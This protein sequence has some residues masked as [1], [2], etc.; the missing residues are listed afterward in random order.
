MRKS[1]YK[2]HIV[3][4]LSLSGVLLLGCILLTAWI[5]PFFHYHKPLQGFRYTID[6]Q[7]S[8]NPGIASTFDYDSVILGS[9]MTINFDTDLFRETMG[10]ETVKLSYNGAFPK[11][12]DNIMPLV[13]N[14]HNQVKEIFLG[15]DISTYKELPGITAYGIPE[16]L[17]DDSLWNDLPYLLNKDVLLEYIMKNIFSKQPGT[18]LNEIYCS[19]HYVE[20]SK[21]NVLA[22]YQAPDR[23]LEPLSAD[24][25]MENIEK[26]MKDYILPYIEAMPETQF[27]VFFPPYSILYWYTQFADG[28]LEAQLQG[29][30]RIM[31]LLFSYPN[32]S[33]YYFQNLY[34]FITDLDHYSDYTHYTHEM[35]DYMTRC[36]AEGT[37]RL[38]KENYEEVLEEMLVRL[39]E[40]DF[41]SYLQ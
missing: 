32:V 11:D 37:C 41:E 29:E 12:I 6:N 3:I 36:F 8:Q 25:Y 14:S 5:D 31:E 40:C 17:Y 38:T 20:C 33:V 7:L 13:Q 35:N 26:N 1:N 15:I 2:K 18:P 39:S 10:L 21:E 4:F 22:S 34:D 19:W 27:T 24:A 30:R 28:S 9:S 16:Y 23:F